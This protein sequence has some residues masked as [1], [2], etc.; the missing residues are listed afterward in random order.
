MAW[1]DSGEVMVLNELVLYAPEGLDLRRRQN[2]GT[3]LFELE[4]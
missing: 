2:P 4:L 1:G 3:G